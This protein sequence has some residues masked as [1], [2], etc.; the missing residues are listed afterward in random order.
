MSTVVRGDIEELEGDLEALRA[1]L[2][3]SPEEQEIVDHIEAAYRGIQQLGLRANQ[4]EL[5]Q[6]THSLQM[7][8]LKH[9][10]QRVGFKGLSRWYWQDTPG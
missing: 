8:V 6:A 4:K 5:D 2:Q 9:A 1:S 3:F 7:F 10:M